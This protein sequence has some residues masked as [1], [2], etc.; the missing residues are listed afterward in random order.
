MLM[1]HNPG[2]YLS[3]SLLLLAGF[4]SCKEKEEEDKGQKEPT[5]L[6]VNGS[7]SCSAVVK[8]LEFSVRCDARW[9]AEL[10]GADWAAIE[11]Q[12]AL[13]DGGSI[14]LRF[15]CNRSG[16]DRTG[17]LVISSGS[18]SV[19]KSITQSSLDKFFMPTEIHL[20]G[21]SE[22]PLV[23]DS[24]AAW[25]VS[26]AEGEDWILIGVTEG[27]SG[28][29]KVPVKAV[30]PNENIGDRSGSLTVTI[31]SEAFTI[32]VMQSQKDVILADNTQVDFAYKGGDFAVITQSN[33]SYQIECEA[34][35]VHHNETKAL[36]QATEL[37][38]VDRNETLS[39]RTAV[40]RFTPVDGTA[41]SVDVKVRQEGMDP[42]LLIT[43]PGFY[44]I[45]SANYFLGNNGWNLC[46][47]VR[48][49]DGS[50][51]FRL[52]NRETLSVLTLKGFDPDAEAG[53]SAHLSVTGWQ[54][55]GKF[56]IREYDVTLLEADES[57]IWLKSEDQAVFI[58]KK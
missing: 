13:A 44:K 45:G 24:P 30:D 8:S 37:F 56:L 43:T 32:P 58:I 5:I 41:A 49:T 12:T 34:D 33:V 54:K 57:L 21:V 11:S 19:R 7:T 38:T 52:M 18:K 1:R 25:T 31:G 20:S 36:N 50:A 26:I 51:E 40:I 53:S 6:Q 47:S 2:F 55:G 15:D 16:E 42:A 17:T 48:N 9:S 28:Y 3:F 23:F 22:V 4:S 39:E 14:V 35:W 27:A 46:S 10:E 29:A